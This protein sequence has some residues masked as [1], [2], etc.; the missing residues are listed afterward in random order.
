MDS[1]Q[2]QDMLQAQDED[3]SMQDAPPQQ[4]APPRRVRV[5]M[6]RLAERLGEDLNQEVVAQRELEAF[7]DAEAVIQSVV[8]HERNKEQVLATAAGLRLGSTQPS[9]PLQPM[10]PF[11]NADVTL[12]QGTEQIVTYLRK[13]SDQATKWTYSWAPDRFRDFVM[14]KKA[15]IS[16]TSNAVQSMTELIQG[17]RVGWDFGQCKLTILSDVKELLR[18]IA[19][20]MEL[21][22]MERKVEQLHQQK[23]VDEKWEE[24][25]VTR[26][27]EAAFA[28][29]ND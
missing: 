18:K 19:A 27:L 12:Q 17:G 1:H 29:D 21:Q 14:T 3:V 16:S 23:I 28:D 9:L 5:R 4:E 24:D 10:N 7:Q 11:Y 26:A 13:L 8:D 25:A 6:R 20:C 2:D 22:R 15:T